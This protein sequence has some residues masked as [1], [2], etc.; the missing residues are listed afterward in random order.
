MTIHQ[1]LNALLQKIVGNLF[2]F[3][4]QQT[5]FAGHVR[6]LNHLHND[7]FRRRQLELEGFAHDLHGTQ[8]LAQGILGHY[9]K[10]SAP[11]YNQQGRHVHENQDIAAGNHGH[12]HNH[13]RTD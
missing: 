11:K 4:G 6:Q 12:H 9:R 13:Q 5:A 10:N 8:K 2:A 3:Q 1:Q 7:F